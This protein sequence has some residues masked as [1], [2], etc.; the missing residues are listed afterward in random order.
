MS[1]ASINIAPN[2]FYSAES[3][4][5]YEFLDT[6]YSRTRPDVLNKDGYKIVKWGSDNL[7]PYYNRQILAENDIKQNLIDT[8][9]NITTGRGLVF[10]RE[11]VEKGKR[12]I[13]YLDEVEAQELFDWVYEW[14]LNEYFRETVQ[15]LKEFGNSWTEFIMSRDGKMVASMMSLDA[16][17]CRLERL[18]DD[19]PRSDSETLLMADWKYR[20]LTDI[21]AIPLLDVRKPQL[22]KY[23][24]SALHI[25]KV[26][27]GQP[28]YSLVEW[29]GTKTWAD[30]ANY[31]P[32]FHKSGLKNGYMLRYHIK[33]PVSVLKSMQQTK[34]P[35]TGQVYTEKEAKAAIQSNID[36]VLGGA[37]K[38][39]KTLFSF[40]NDTMPNPSEW[41]IEKI[42]TDLKDD[43]YIKL[44]DTASKVHARGHN[45][46]PVLAGI[47][48]SGSLSS[49]SEIMNLLN[50]QVKYKTQR[51]RDL[52]LKA[53]KLVK[54]YNF[55]DM[56]DIKIG[57]E[58]IEFTTMDKNPMG[59]Q[60]GIQ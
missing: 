44:F 12:V 5:V 28:Y 56:K 48:T 7:L 4:V 30:I 17:D 50:Y 59:Q 27:S 39:Q 18:K 35:E 42:E 46:H 45:L 37:D 34:N 41:K 15:D 10:Y 57:V 33:I 29:H 47:E 20:V 21:Q 43:S 3:G 36:S 32:K 25:K 13:E 16:V 58:D 19:S 38:S 2:V 51:V 53:I 8:D 60:S 26:I 14:N 9:V 40:I 55:P 31:V 24:K 22:G 23:Y 52:A 54:D 11:K 1:E 49:G 6:T